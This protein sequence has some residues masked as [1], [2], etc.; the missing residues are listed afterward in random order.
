[1]TFT[2]DQK[3]PGEFVARIVDRDYSLDEIIILGGV[4]GS[5]V[6]EAG[7]ILAELAQTATSLTETEGAGN[8]GDGTM[9][10]ATQGGFLLQEGRY[11]LQCVAA[12]ANAG[13]FIITAPDGTRVVSVDGSD[14]TV[15]VAFVSEHFS[16]TLADGAADFIVGDEAYVDVVLASQ[17]YGLYDAS[18][19][20]GSQ[21]VI[22]VL[23]NNVTAL[24]SVDHKGVALVRGP[25]IVNAAML[26]HDAGA[27][28]AEKANALA[29]LER[30]GILSRTG[31]GVVHFAF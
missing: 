5:R 21:N 1:M 18:A 14:L 16:V 11:E 30:L 6:L 7:S 24:E 26:T 13:R 23:F 27:G 22:G 3:R 9:G 25:V 2:A 31:V 19:E 12:A 15:A 4:G 20:D 8:T 28:V 17:K 29:Q 10:T